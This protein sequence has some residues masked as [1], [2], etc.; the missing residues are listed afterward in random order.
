MSNSILDTNGQSDTSVCLF[1]CL[2]V[3]LFVRPSVRCLSGASILWVDEAW[4]FI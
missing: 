3:S 4:C 2:S 1:D